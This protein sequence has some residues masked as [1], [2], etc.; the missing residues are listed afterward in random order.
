[1]LFLFFASSGQKLYKIVSLEGFRK[2]CLVDVFSSPL[3][4]FSCIQVAKDTLIVIQIHAN[5]AL[6]HAW[7]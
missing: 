4:D 3:F 6:P 1:M 7:S 2:V 5:V